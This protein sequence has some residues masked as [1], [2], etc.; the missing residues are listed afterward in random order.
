MV[1]TSAKFN[2]YGMIVAII[3]G[4]EKTFAD[5]MINPDRVL[6]SEWE[7]AG[8]TIE[9][10]VA[11]PASI[12]QVVSRFQARAALHLAGLLPDVET[13]IAAADPLVQMAWADAQ[14]FRRDSPTI[15]A[16]AGA[17][18]LSESEVDELFTS[19]AQI[20]A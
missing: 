15:V 3:D 19:A 11:P 5:E 6:V 16:M 2:Q 9:P 8:N 14:E 13:A 17:L 1:V 12:P 4:I 20:V 18:G 7:A 10:Y